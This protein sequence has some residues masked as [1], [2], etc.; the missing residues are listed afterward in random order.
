MRLA[1]VGLVLGGFG[2]ESAATAEAA[3]TPW[4]IANIVRGGVQAVKVVKKVGQRRA[5]KRNGRAY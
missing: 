2:W 5:A 1:V 3:L 4:Q